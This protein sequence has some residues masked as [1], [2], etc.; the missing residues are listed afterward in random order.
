[1]VRIVFIRH[2]QPDFSLADERRHTQLEKDY[3][4]LDRKYLDRVEQTASDPRLADS[5]IVLSSPY[6]RALQT[7]EII[8]R[9]LQLPLFVEFDLHDWKADLAGGYL[10]LE[11]RDRRWEEYKSG[12]AGDDGRIAAKPY[13]SPDSLQRRVRNV[14]GR[15]SG[16]R[17]IIVVSHLN[18]ICAQVGDLRLVVPCAGIL[19]Y[20]LNL[21]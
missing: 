9:R 14:L 10:A 19:E 6:T 16:Y 21:E 7:A 17:K 2:G 12:R 4:P 20:D 5:E 3:S 13:E 11:E 15:Y 1:M 8:N 18:V